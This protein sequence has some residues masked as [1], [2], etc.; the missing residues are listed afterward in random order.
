MNIEGDG[1]D[2]YI[3]PLDVDSFTEFTEPE[4]KQLYHNTTGVEFDKLVTRAQLKTI[5]YHTIRKILPTKTSELEL[6][7]QTKFVEK[8]KGPRY[9]YVNGSSKPGICTELFEFEAKKTFVD[10]KME[11][12][13]INGTIPS[14]IKPT[15]AKRKT[16]DKKP[17]PRP[18]RR[19][20][21]VKTII[22]KVADE[23]WNKAGCPKDKKE[24]LTLRKKIMDILGEAEGINRSTASS[25]LGAWQKERIT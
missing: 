6:E 15:I 17:K 22:F 8:N 2:V 14:V 13:V 10:H 19:S 24:V 20:G 5:L 23:E 21:A 12:K 25:T 7:V 3:L 1:I 9:V 4:L 16:T 11:Q 18:L